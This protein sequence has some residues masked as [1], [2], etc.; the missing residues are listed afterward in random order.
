MVSRSNNRLGM[1]ITENGWVPFP[2]MF[3]QG[4][5]HCTQQRDSAHRLAGSY[6]ARTRVGPENNRELTTVAQHKVSTETG[7][8]APCH[9]SAPEILNP[10]HPP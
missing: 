4:R 5:L 1:A 10:Q 6:H 9:W 7:S 3:T 8:Y 2:H